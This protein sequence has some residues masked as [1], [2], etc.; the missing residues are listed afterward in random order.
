MTNGDTGNTHCHNTRHIKGSGKGMLNHNIYSHI[1]MGNY[2]NTDQS[3]DTTQTGD[4]HSNHTNTHT[5]AMRGRK[6]RVH[7]NT[8]IRRKRSTPQPHKTHPRTPSFSLTQTHTI[9]FNPKHQHRM[10]QAYFVNQKNPQEKYC[11]LLSLLSTVTSSALC[12]RKRR[13]T[14]NVYWVFGKYFKAIFCPWTLAL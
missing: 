7:T 4:G 6:R 8:L 14:P 2:T 10:T 3:T 12:S 5:E 13:P 1:T 11:C 9:W